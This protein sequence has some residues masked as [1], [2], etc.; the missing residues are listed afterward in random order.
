MDPYQQASS[1]FWSFGREEGE[2]PPFSEWQILPVQL[3]SDLRLSRRVGLRGNLAKGSTVH[4]RVGCGEL[5]MVKSVKAFKTE[6]QVR[7]LT[8]LVQGNFLEDGE[9]RRAGSRRRTLGRYL[10]AVPIAYF[11]AFTATSVDST[12]DPWFEK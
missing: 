7:T 6:L 9:G 10:G 4:H 3:Q 11:G 1:E 12:V 5:W 8:K 2:P